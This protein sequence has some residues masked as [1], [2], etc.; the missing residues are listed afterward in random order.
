MYALPCFCPPRHDQLGSCQQ[1]FQ[2]ARIS[3]HPTTF[4]MPF[5][6]CSR[7]QIRSVRY[8]ADRRKAARSSRRRPVGCEADSAP[9]P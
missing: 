2:G 9:R 5:K 3:G 8:L 4:Y 1:G 7:H 6:G